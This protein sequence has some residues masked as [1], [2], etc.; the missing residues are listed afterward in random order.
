MSSAR[1]GDQD[2][3][4]ELARI[5]G[6]SAYIFALQLTGRPETAR[7]VAQDSLLSFFRNLDRFDAARPVDP[8]LFQIVRN[9]VRDLYRRERLRRHDSLDVWLEHGATVATDPA[10]GPAAEAERHELQRRVWLAISQLGDGHREILVLR[11]FHD[12]TYREIAEVLSIPHGTV[13]SRLH[14]ARSRLREALLAESDGFFDD[15]MGR[16]E[17]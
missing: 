13:M 14:A 6:R 11:D 3:Q 7:D 5:V 10:V 9:R 15:S 17:R 1:D 16:D 2:A 4:E 8:W 12:L